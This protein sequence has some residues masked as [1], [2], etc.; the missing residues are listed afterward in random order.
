MRIMI[1]TEE[2]EFY[3]PL[4]IQHI[5][6]T[7][8]YDI[9]EIICARNP[10][11]P[12]K[13]KAL[14]KFYK[15][16][17]IVPIA[18]HCLRLLKA[19]MLDKIPALNFTGRYYS[20]EQ[21]CKAFNKPYL[22]IKNINSEDFLNHC[23]QLNIDLI[24]SVSPTQIFKKQLINLPKYGCINIHT[25][26]LPKYRGLYPVYWAMACGE[27]NL[28]VSIHYIEEGIDTGKIILQEEMDIPP[29]STMDYM[30]RITKIKGAELLVKAI[31]QISQ[32]TV[33]AF[34]PQEQG[35]YFSFPTPES[36]TNFRNYGY[37]LW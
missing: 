24:A 37:K 2:D 20:I 17:G 15:T 21:L 16:F 33:Q 13:L 14:N 4:S 5:L 31:D 27:K 35:N 19:K 34:Y 28:G 12:S 7:C 8:P 22:F 30:L 18:K 3:L 29:Y 36:Y 26:K 25:A 32:G 1:I 9:V 11:V 6:Q 10:L 23:R